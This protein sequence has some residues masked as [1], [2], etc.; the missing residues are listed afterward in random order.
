MSKK[1]DALRRGV[2]S[3]IDVT[4]RELAAL[5]NRGP[6]VDRRPGAPAPR[7]VRDMLPNSPPP[8][9]TLE[10][11]LAPPEPAPPHAP[12]PD[13]APRLSPEVPLPAAETAPPAGSEA[14]AAQAISEIEPAVRAVEPTVVRP[15]RDA[16]SAEAVPWRF[17]DGTREVNR[18]IP[19][20]PNGWPKVVD[21][22]PVADRPV[23]R[24]ADP[25]ANSAVRAPAAQPPALDSTEAVSP[26]PAGALPPAS[27]AAR[28][29]A[30]GSAKP[31]RG[32]RRARSRTDNRASA[33]T[34]GPARPDVPNSSDAPRGRPRTATPGATTRRA[35][36]ER[37][38][39][40]AGDPVPDA[41]DP[42]QARGK[43]GVCF[44]YFI[45]HACWRVPEA[46]C[47]K[48]LQTC[49][50]RQCPVYHLHRDALE[51]RFAKKFKHFW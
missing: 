24:T 38:R 6:D 47:N 18:T 51:Q 8:S 11:L 22:A 44:A 7:H 35:R 19:P 36:R 49:I 31:G 3:L 48:A 1:R 17:L 29:E 45:N 50:I 28:R 39:E 27:T 20:P 32:T 21:E 25:A 4:S 14:A 40:T 2:R 26:A 12:A 43:T 5:E 23:S 16:G 41:V 15:P 42:A 37:D 10:S 9:L 13:E 46:Y 33:G 30:E 34:R